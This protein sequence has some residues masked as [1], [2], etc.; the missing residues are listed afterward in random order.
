MEGHRSQVTRKQGW[1][2][3]RFNYKQLNVKDI[4]GGI[5][6]ENVFRNKKTG[7]IE[8]QPLRA[9]F[10]NPNSFRKE[11]NDLILNL[12]IEGDMPIK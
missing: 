9:A 10:T 2:F 1:S 3:H 5:T 8:N 12:V 7:H 11:N 4:P 6:A